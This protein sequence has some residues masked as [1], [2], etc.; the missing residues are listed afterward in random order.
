[1]M[2][3]NAK[4]GVITNWQDLLA[5]ADLDKDTLKDLLPFEFVLEREG[6]ELQENNSGELVSLCPFHDDHDPS[7]KLW[8]E[9]PF[10]F[11][12]FPCGINGDLYDFLMKMHGL[13]FKGAV[14]AALEHYKEFRHAEDWKPRVVAA[15]RTPVEPRDFEREAREAWLAAKEERLATI[16]HLLYTKNMLEIPAQWLHEEFGVGSRP[17]DDAVIIPHLDAN[18]KVTGYKTRWSAGHPIAARG[19]SYPELYGGWRDTGRE[20]IIFCEGE[21]D[22]W[23][24]AYTFRDSHSVVGLPTGAGQKP[25][26]ELCKRFKDREVILLFD[27]DVAGRAASRRWH[28]ALEPVAKRVLI[29]PMEDGADAVTCSNLV[30]IVADAKVVPAEIGNI[31]IDAEHRYVYTRV[32]A[33]GN[34]NVAPLCDWALDFESDGRYLEGEDSSAWEGH[35]P[36]GQLVVLSAESFKGKKNME[37][38][39]RTHGF[40]WVGSDR[41]VQVLYNYLQREAPFLRFGK[42]TNIAGLHEGHFV[43][44]KHELAPNGICIGPRYWRYIE[45]AA[46]PRLE[47]HYE[48]LPGNWNPNIVYNLLSLHEQTVTTPVLAWMAAAPLRSLFENFPPLGVIGGSGYGKSTLVGAFMKAFYGWRETVTLAD[49]TPWAIFAYAQAT[50]GI[51]IWFDEYRYGIRQGAK[52][53]IDQILR[54]AWDGASLVKGGLDQQNYQRLSHMPIISPLV[55]SGEDAFTEV[56]HIERMVIINLP[57]EGRS[58]SALRRLAEISSAGFGYSYLSWLSDKLIDGT[59]PAL[60]AMGERRPETTQNIL[61]WGWEVFTDFCLETLNHTLPELDLTQ[62][63]QES[64]DTIP[65]II[66]AVQWAVGKF[67]R[68]DSAPIVWCDSEHVYV[69]LQ[70]L[71]HLV[72]LDGTFVLPGG[73]RSMKK[74]LQSQFITDMV[75]TGHGPAMQLIGAKNELFPE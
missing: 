34:S 46:D 66:E 22:T 40:S 36:N 20:R 42:M 73:A 28:H 10:R 60:P 12:C 65:P 37:Q 59:L 75:R 21:S 48:I 8:G 14:E 7:F 35:L 16:N 1:M 11:G 27:G 39:S 49:T 6:V 4:T 41:D 71:A 29:A 67:D 51:P 43:L 2:A 30:S 55:V 69:R 63:T 32:Q 19:S 68:R 62:T 70:E 47:K 56:S 45:P 52:E 23:K 74:W 31:Q 33:N 25:N 3:V 64:E 50:N 9:H 44:P 58:P 72:K 18:K 13:D 26:T 24:T 54:A 17:E 15:S 38:W 53:A 61:H 5:V 57:R